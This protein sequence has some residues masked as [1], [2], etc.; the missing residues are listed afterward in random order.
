MPQAERGFAQGVLPAIKQLTVSAV[1]ACA[2]RD[3]VAGTLAAGSAVAAC[4]AVAGR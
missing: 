1:S 2:A 3:T 4:A